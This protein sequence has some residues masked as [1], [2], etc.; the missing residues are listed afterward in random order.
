MKKL[1]KSAQ[2]ICL[3]AAL[4]CAF[5]LCLAEAYTPESVNV[6]GAFTVNA[7]VPEGY[8]F[9][10]EYVSSI[11]YF[12][13]L[14]PKDP[15][16]PSALITIAFD[17]EANGRSIG[18]LTEE[19]LSGMI[20][21]EKAVLGENVEFSQAETSHGTKLLVFNVLDE[22]EA[23]FEI[24]TLYKGYQVGCVILPGEGHTMT[25]EHLDMAVDFL[26]EVWIDG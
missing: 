16:Y 18:D 9:R 10:G 2:V 3:A 23:R 24:Y 5:S 11:L 20:A 8:S 15:A 13:T 6:M 17:E 22:E 26:S 21:S 12:G 1:S 19:E 14:S 7:N 4:L 25:R